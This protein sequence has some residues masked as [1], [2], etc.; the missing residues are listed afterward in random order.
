M[1]RMIPANLSPG[2]ESKAEE[3]LFHALR[4]SLDDSHIV[5]HSFDILARN[6][7]NKPI[8]VEIDFLIFHQSKGLLTLEVKG[9]SIAYDGGQWMQNGRPLNKSPYKQAKHNKYAVSN[10]LEKRLG[11]IPPMVLGHA[12]C[13]P[14]VFTQMSNLPAEADPDITITGNLIH[15]LDSVI[16]QIFK[17]YQRG[18]H[19][20]LKPQVS[21]DVRRA[22]IPAFEYGTGLVDAMGM[23]EQ[24]IFR[25]TEEQ[26][27]YLDF[28]GNRKRVLV[29]GCA[30]T[31]KTILALKKAR[32][33][34]HDGK[35]VLLLCYNVPLGNLLE[36][37]TKTMAKNITATNY[38]RFCINKLQEAGINLPQRHD[39]DFWEIEIP[40]RFD[41]LLDKHPL[42]YDAI[43]VDEGQDFKDVYWI[44]IGKMLSGDGYYYIFYDPD[45]NLYG[46]DMKFPID[47]E[48]FVLKTN[49][50]NTRRVC[51]TLT[52]YTDQEII[53]K[54]DAPEGKPI[55]EIRCS[56][57][58]DCRK[59]LGRILHKLVNEEGISPA[60]IVVLGGHRIEHT[61]LA[62]NP[63]IG[64][65]TLDPESESNT[66][67]IRYETY[68][69][70]KGC[71]AD[72]VIL[73]DVDVKD[74]NWNRNA[75]YT[76]ISRSKFLLYILYRNHS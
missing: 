24:H 66:N 73:F 16:P 50:R 18:K 14:D 69:R 17:N 33:L 26:C 34:A 48:P 44:T 76:A 54:E 65:F 4:D 3:M 43:I 74:K 20:S 70:F 5:F 67:G 37:S 52:G 63:K 6:L 9:G 51:E 35:S 38:H 46:S 29:K 49:C 61:S 23:A 8:D 75:F 41:K 2:T 21:E 30:G 7:D 22:L 62:G 11:T 36:E 59:E 39:S 27:R 13:F 47:E 40:D 31:G 72:V 53:L 64:N 58:Q 15:H 12:V 57:K 1:A 25:L 10:Y 28:I 19:C 45:Q 71:E 55:E 68:F 42:K 60:G 32:E 56:S